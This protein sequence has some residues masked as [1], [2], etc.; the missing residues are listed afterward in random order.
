[1]AA[2][3]AALEGITGGREPS[4]AGMGGLGL[5]EPEGAASGCDWL[6]GLALGDK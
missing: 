2:A 6:A 3:V 4:A 5:V 1:M